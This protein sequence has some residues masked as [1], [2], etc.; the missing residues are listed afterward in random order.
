M[1]GNVLFV[2]TA[3]TQLFIEIL[4]GSSYLP[5]SK[6]LYIFCFA[7]S[8]IKIMYA[9]I[10]AKNEEIARKTRLTDLFWNLQILFHFKKIFIGHFQFEVAQIRGVLH[11]WGG[12]GVICSLFSPGPKMPKLAGSRAAETLLQLGSEPLRLP[13][14]IFSFCWFT[15]RYSNWNWGRKLTFRQ[16]TFSKKKIVLQVS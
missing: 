13:P 12:S 15:I 10:F 7:C 2:P 1:T 3:I 4:H 8:H 5:S 9:N 16:H 6:F 11:F 14:K